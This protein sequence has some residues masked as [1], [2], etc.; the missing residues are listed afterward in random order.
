M[1]LLCYIIDPALLY[2][3]YDNIDYNVSLVYNEDGPGG[4]TIPFLVN[5]YSNSYTLYLKSWFSYYNSSHI[6]YN[7]PT[8]FIYLTSSYYFYNIAG[9]SL[10]PF[11]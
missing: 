3:P 9:T 5:N 2:D 8:S 11:Y 10:F 1:F 6:S 7:L 4:I